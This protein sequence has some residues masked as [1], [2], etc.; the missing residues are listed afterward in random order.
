MCSATIAI[1]SRRRGGGDSL[2]PS[3]SPFDLPPGL[4]KAIISQHTTQ[5]S[6]RVTDSA[7]AAAGAAT[8]FGEFSAARRRRRRRGVLPT[9]RAHSQTDS[10]P[11]RFTGVFSYRPLPYLR[12]PSYPLRC[13]RAAE[14]LT[15]I[16]LSFHIRV[17]CEVRRGIHHVFIEGPI[18][19]PYP[20]YPKNQRH[21]RYIP[22]LI[23]KTLL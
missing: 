14:K 8:L 16:V 21:D 23:T 5:F 20:P 6:T 12:I 3:L 7:A 17:F 18:F 4:K 10:A 2:P 15:R 11:F 22:H 9:R 1:D 19:S 13:V